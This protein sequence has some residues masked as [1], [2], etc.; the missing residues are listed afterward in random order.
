MVPLALVGPATSG[1]KTASIIQSG[2]TTSAR[3]VVQKTTGKTIGEHA[4]DAVFS[5]DLEASLKQSY[6][7]SEESRVGTEVRT[8]WSP[9]NS[10]KNV[11]H[12]VTVTFAAG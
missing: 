1:F 11:K 2:I 10:K 5:D 7:R 4:F 12:V 6:C 9:Q 8:R 3:Y